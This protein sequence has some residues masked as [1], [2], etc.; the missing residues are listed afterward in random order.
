MRILHMT[1]ADVSNGV[2]HYIFSHMR[3][4]DTEEFA[5]AFLTKG[6]QALEQTG[7]W[8]KYGFPT[9]TLHH[10]QRDDREGMVREI[11][12]ILAEG[13]DAIHLHTS[14]WRGFLIEEIAM[15]MGIKRVIVHSHSTGIDA[16]DRELRNRLE[17]ENEAYRRAFSM[18]YATDLCA[19]S[20]RAADWLFGPQIPRE[21]ILILPN[22]VDVDKYG[23]DPEKRERIRMAL[24]IQ[25]K[26]V[27][28]NIGRY[29]YS[30]NQ[31]FL[32]RAFARAHAKNRN[33]FLLF[34]GEGELL[35]NMEALAGN[36]G[37]ANS[38]RCL[39]WQKNPEDY[40]QAMDVFCL[41]SRFEGLPISAVEAQAAGLRCLVSDRVS[42]EVGITELTD[43][44][45]LEEQVWAQAIL[46]C[47]ADPHRR[48]WDA[49]IADAGYDI[50]LAAGRLAQFYR[51]QN[52]CR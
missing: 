48:R 42:R 43:F 45:P 34:L 9:Y 10:T 31:E 35:K 51:G 1:P 18:E 4:M 28:G 26:T 11:R 27:V 30:K 38:V 32:I 40:L 50:R 13:F 12:G 8:K 5:F 2:Y 52:V 44:L 14:S 22:A 16:S 6:A 46:E 23:F 3:H 37:I 17:K 33:L 15:E 29:S 20:A 24:G 36:L 25:R 21:R 19:C 49:Q 7:E 39:G 41:P 47:G